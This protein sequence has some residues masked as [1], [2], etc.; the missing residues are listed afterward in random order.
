[1]KVTANNE[2]VSKQNYLWWYILAQADS[3]SFMWTTVSCVWTTA[4]ALVSI[5]DMRSKGAI[6]YN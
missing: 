2:H 4:G 5:H 6:T 3:K 1:L